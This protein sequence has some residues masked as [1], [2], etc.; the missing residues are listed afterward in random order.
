MASTGLDRTVTR[1]VPGESAHEVGGKALTRLMLAIDGEPCRFGCTYCFAQ[2]AQ[3]EQPR[4]LSELQAEPTLARDVD[5]IYPACDTDLFARSDFEEILQTV[6]KFGKSISISTKASIGRRAVAA[7]QATTVQ[8]E[9]SGAVLKVG[10]SVSTKYSVAEIEPRTPGYR[11]RVR[12][13]AQLKSAGIANSLVFRPLL[14]DVSDREYEEIMRDCEGLTE[15]ILLGDE[16]LDAG[17]R[18]RVARGADAT[19]VISVR[20]VGWARS[21]PDWAQRYIP[22]RA[23]SLQ[24]Y[25]ESLGFRVFDSDASLMG[26]VIG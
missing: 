18:F 24:S 2:F 9:K 7:L 4:T 3:Y 14:A 13:L 6:A 16:W 11:S 26:D 19:P 8:L 12:S 20:S 25:G 5:V 22:G 23:Q 15:R 21:N 1:L 17:D 10:V